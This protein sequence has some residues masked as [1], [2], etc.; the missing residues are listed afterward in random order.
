MKKKK[1]VDISIYLTTYYAVYYTSYGMWIITMG[2]ISLYSTLTIVEKVAYEFTII[3]QRSWIPAGFF[4]I[5]DA[6]HLF[7]FDT[8]IITFKN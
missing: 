1:E 7:Y 6:H 5:K 4:F 8:I 3:I 2:G